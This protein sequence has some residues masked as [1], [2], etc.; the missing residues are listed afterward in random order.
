ML[1]QLDKSLLADIS[2]PDHGLFQ[3]YIPSNICAA[4]RRPGNFYTPVGKIL[5]SLAKGQIGLA[6]IPLILKAF[7]C[8]DSDFEGNVNAGEVLRRAQGKF[9]KRAYLV[10]DSYISIR[11]G[12]PTASQRISSFGIFT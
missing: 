6:L 4:V 3:A 11:R 2:I 9:K 1:I 7:F 8:V 5:S 12:F 10:A